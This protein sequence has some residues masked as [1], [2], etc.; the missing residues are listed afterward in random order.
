MMLFLATWSFQKNRKGVSKLASL[1]ES[2]YPGYKYN[3]SKLQPNLTK[4]NLMLLSEH[5]E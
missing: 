5:V 4:P 3:E 1:V 2:G